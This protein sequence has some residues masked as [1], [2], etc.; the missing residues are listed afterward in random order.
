MAR[1]QEETST[2]QARRKRGIP[3]ESPTTSNLVAIMTVEELRSFCKVL[4]DIS[5]ELLY[6]VAVSIV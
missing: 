4:V 2:S 1:D 3:R 6:G 5:L